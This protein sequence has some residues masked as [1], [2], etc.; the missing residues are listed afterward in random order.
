MER[1]GENFIVESVGNFSAANKTPAALQNKFGSGAAVS[2]AMV[3]PCAGHVLRAAVVAREPVFMR[4]RRRC[5]RWA[6]GAG[7]HAAASSRPYRQAARSRASEKSLKN[8]R[9]NFDLSPTCHKDLIQAL[10]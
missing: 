1:V 9:G 6:L 7:K 5:G 3:A 4:F 10:V 8:S 2:A